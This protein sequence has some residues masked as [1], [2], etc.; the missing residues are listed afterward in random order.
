MFGSEIKPAADEFDFD[1]L[2]DDQDVS[3]RLYEFPPLLTF[4]SAQRKK[5]EALAF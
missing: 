3:T 5:Q 1:L 2:G 4:L